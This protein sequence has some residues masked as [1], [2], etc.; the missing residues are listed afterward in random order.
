MQA[1]FDPGET[2]LVS[3]DKDG[4]VCCWGTDTLHQLLRLTVNAPRLSSCQVW[5]ARCARGRSEHTSARSRELLDTEGIELGRHAFHMEMASCGSQAGEDI[6]ATPLHV[7]DV[8]F[9]SD[10]CDILFAGVAGELICIDSVSGAT[11]WSLPAHLHKLQRVHFCMSG[12][13][14]HVVDIILVDADGLV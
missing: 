14:L 4:I 2:R 1:C 5:S 11:I 12:T 10:G 3:V 7:H 8:A 6:E 9:V 13:A